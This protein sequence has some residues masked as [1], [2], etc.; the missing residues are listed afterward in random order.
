M[1]VRGTSAKPARPVS[2]AAMV[3]AV[4]VLIGI[5]GFSA[6]RS[7]APPPPLLPPKNMVK[8]AQAQWLHTK[9]MECSGDLKKLSAEDQAKVQQFSRGF[10][11]LVIKDEYYRTKN[12]Q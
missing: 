6:Y 3:G 2:P 12:G 9:A 10:G 5:V 4:A 7:L 11:D 1:T 8:S